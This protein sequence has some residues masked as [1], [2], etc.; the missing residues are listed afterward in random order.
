MPMNDLIRLNVGGTSLT[1]S[2]GTLLS[3]PV[4]S[5]AK[6]FQEDSPISPAILHNGEYFLD[7]DSE[8][9]KVIS[10]VLTTK[11]LKEIFR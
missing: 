7:V 9:F 11:E 3:D 6:M 2:R 8:C 1:T 10:I 4:S 5:L